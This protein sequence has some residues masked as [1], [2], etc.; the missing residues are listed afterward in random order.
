M[1]LVLEQRYHHINS[2][3]GGIVA[4]LA[5]Y[6]YT[7]QCWVNRSDSEAVEQRFKIIEQADL[8]ELMYLI[9]DWY[10]QNRKENVEK[11]Q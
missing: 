6:N 5:P 10:K 3:S 11:I 7:P 9:V 4:R 8:S 1:F 2:N